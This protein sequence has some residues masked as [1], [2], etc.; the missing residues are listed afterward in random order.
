MAVVWE[1]S[2][3]DVTPG[4][5]ASW[6]DVD[7]SGQAS[8]PSGCTGVILRIL[9][10]S[11]TSNEDIGLRKN[12]STDARIERL[13][14]EGQTPGYIGVDG[15]GIFEAYCESSNLTVY[16]VGYFTTEATFNTNATDKSLGTTGAWTDVDISSDTGG[17][18]A[19][20]AIIEAEGTN[21]TQEVLFRKNGSTDT[22]VYDPIDSHT[23][24]IVGVDGSE[25]YE[26][27]TGG[28]AG[29][30]YLVGYITTDITMHTNRTDVTPTGDGAYEDLTALPTG[31]NGGIY[32][33]LA[34]GNKVNVRKNG[35]SDDWYYKPGG[36]S[37][38]WVA[39]EAD[40]SRIVEGI[41][42]G[43]GGEIY[44]AGY[45][46]GATT[47]PSSGGINFAGGQPTKYTIKVDSPVAGKFAFGGQIP[48]FTAVKLSQPSAGSFNF[49]GYSPTYTE[50][51]TKPNT[52]GFFVF[53]GKIVQTIGYGWSAQAAVTSNWSAIPSQGS[54]YTIL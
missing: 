45:F 33:L 8:F 26:C 29:D 36:H 41:C 12:G 25:I 20:A 19:V 1:T 3:V 15:S 9:N 23:W 46:E 4:S 11:T 2:P 48:T 28:L 13:V 43:A 5:F 42:E 44:E 7:V 17:A 27:Y 24:L 54:D 47:F 30:H 39:V 38:A 10:T 21:T 50:V 35:S 49:T 31:S 52:N 51:I 40:A 37:Y 6:V 18:T 53:K 34:G 22:H 32:L 14:T 16:L